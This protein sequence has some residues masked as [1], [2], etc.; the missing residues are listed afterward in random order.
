MYY[1][2][3]LLLFIL[4]THLFYLSNIFIFNHFYIF[5]SELIYFL[6]WPRWQV[7]GFGILHLLPFF[8][9]Y[10]WTLIRDSFSFYHFWIRYTFIIF[11][12][13]SLYN[14]WPLG[15]LYFFPLIFPTLQFSSSFL[16][17]F[18]LTLNYLWQLHIFHIIFII[19]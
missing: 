4:H 17:S 15:K 11:L 1:Y 8:N 3:N 6:F 16:Y 13:R 12:F 14:F 18:L 2:S 7:T 10:R 5:F 9:L 19:Y